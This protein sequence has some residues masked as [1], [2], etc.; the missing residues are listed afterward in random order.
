MKKG[1][2]NA[3]MLKIQQTVMNNTRGIQDYMQDLNSWI[4]DTTKSETKNVQK[5]AK[6]RMFSKGDTRVLNPPFLFPLEIN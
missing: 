1:G 4:S 3:D 2:P 5:I 6:V